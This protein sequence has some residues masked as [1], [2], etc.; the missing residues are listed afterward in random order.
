MTP[1]HRLFM[2]GKECVL[3]AGALEQARIVFRFVRAMLEGC[4]DY[5]FVDSSQRVSLLHIPTNT[6]LRMISS[7]ARTAFGLVNNPL[8]VADEPGSWEVRGG[9]LMHDALSTSLGK[10]GSP[11]RVI[12]IG[13]L[14]PAQRGW[15]HDLIKDGSRGSRHVTALKGDPDK[16]DQW[17]EIRR[18]NP[19]ASMDSKF[20]AKLLEERDEARRDTRLKARF[21]SYRLNYPTA[22]EIDVLLTESDWKLVKAR[23]VP[24]AIGKPIVGL[25]LGQGRSW[26]AAV[27]IWPNGRCE[28]RAVAPGIPDIEAQEHRDRVPTGTYRRLFEAPECSTWRTVFMCRL[29]RCWCNGLCR[30]GACRRGL[31]LTAFA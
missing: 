3:M 30:P 20:R 22:D 16:W 1:G 15:W 9:E 27:A 14:A 17:S 4:N 31:W 6:R 18:C 21:L 11:M 5:K 19:L 10:P 13:T 26:S 12:Y 23:A 29:C 2:A 28:A 7:N 25:D 24:P 8:V